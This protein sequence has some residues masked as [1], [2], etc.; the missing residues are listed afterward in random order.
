M[1]SSDPR[2]RL[3]PNPPR[4]DYNGLKGVRLV[5]SRIDD[6]VT[7]LRAERGPSHADLAREVAGWD[8]AERSALVE[9][10]IAEPG[11]RRWL[12]GDLLP[13]LATDEATSLALRLLGFPEDLAIEHRDRTT[14]AL[15][16]HLPLETLGEQAPV[17]AGSNVA[18]ALWRRVHY[19][20]QERLSDV[21]LDVLRRGDPIARETTLHLLVLDPYSHVRLTGPAR[22][23][24]LSLGL[25][26]EE[27]D[28][29]GL[30]ADAL[31][32]EA[33]DRL[34][35]GL[36][37]WTRDPNERVRMAAWDVAFADD[38]RSARTVAEAMVTDESCPLPAR[39]SALVALGAT[40]ST[41]EIAPLLAALVIH[42]DATL[43]EDAAGLLWA[44]HRTP[45]AAEAAS[46]SPHESV[47][48]IADRLLH[49][50]FGSP[51]AGGSRPG[52]P[53]DR[54]DIYDQMIRGLRDIDPDPSQR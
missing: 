16:R 39:R 48:V 44:E 32:E 29:R 38:H 19:E 3:V 18:A 46:R 11:P 8:L 6:A 33:P 23:A 50:D 2:P 7:A 36:D 30:A 52:A 49:P 42:P 51:A 15:V 47:R 53:D 12:R 26:D 10:I 27:G 35:P 40:L 43:A 4:L 14:M 37:R 20:D 24:L 45:I 9:Q 1:K 31:A 28:I 25:E 41:A 13:R 21:A 34:R 17:L 5:T 54:R 22:L